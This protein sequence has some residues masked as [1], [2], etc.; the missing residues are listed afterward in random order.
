MAT[1]LNIHPAIVFAIAT[2]SS[3]VIFF[4]V[5]FLLHVFYAKAARRWPFVNR[6]IE[7]VRKKGQS[8]VEKHGFLGLILFIAVPLPATGVYGGALLS[9]LLSM[10]WQTSLLAV[11][12]GSTVSNG[13]VTLSA[14]GISQAV[15]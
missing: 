12:L 1:V 8:L 5:R 10:K 2:A 4:A 9:W 3:V 15:S 11:I 13:I 14:L 6:R 7:V